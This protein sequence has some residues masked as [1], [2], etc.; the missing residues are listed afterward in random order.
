MTKEVR[1]AFDGH[2]SQT[3]WMDSATKMLAREKVTD[4]HW[5][6]IIVGSQ[7]VILC[8]CF[9][10]CGQLS[11]HPWTSTGYV[12][13]SNLVLRLINPRDSACMSVKWY[14]DAFDY[15]TFEGKN[16]PLFQ[17]NYHKEHLHNYVVIPEN[18]MNA[19]G[20]SFSDLIETNI[21]SDELILY[22][23]IFI[24]FSLLKWIIILVIQTGY[25]TIL[26]YDW[27][28]MGWVWMIGVSLFDTKLFLKVIGSFCKE[29]KNKNCASQFSARFVKLDLLVI[30]DGMFSHLLAGVWGRYIF[31]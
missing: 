29:I 12:G 24:C 25:T 14:S 26:H 28:M 22:Y 6:L 16:D 7:D 20:E 11:T 13:Y 8:E 5:V 19:H 1:K 31:P 2:L 27:D 3:D 30:L 17:N 15:K 21:S 23:D 18:V 4:P 9:E 10:P